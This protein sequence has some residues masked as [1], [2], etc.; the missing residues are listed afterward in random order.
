MLCIKYLLFEANW[1][2]NLTN[3]EDKTIINPSVR[4]LALALVLCNVSAYCVLATIAFLLPD[5]L[6]WLIDHLDGIAVVIYSSF[7]ISLLLT[8][9]FKISSK[10]KRNQ[11]AL[12]YAILFI[13][14]LVTFLVYYGLGQIGQ[15]TWLH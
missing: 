6:N 1:E 4:I 14:N 3:T 11:I 2:M 8:C 10:Q 7:I 15:D 5:K 9:F 13:W 12:T